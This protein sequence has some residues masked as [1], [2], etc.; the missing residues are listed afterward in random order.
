MSE[1]AGRRSGASPEGWGGEGGAAARDGDTSLFGEAV[2]VVNCSYPP[3][4]SRSA[5]SFTRKYSV[6]LI[7]EDLVQNLNLPVY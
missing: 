6:I 3:I 4:K 1:A 2:I 7:C 5:F